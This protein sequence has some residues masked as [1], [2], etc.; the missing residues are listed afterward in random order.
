[1]TE[2]PATTISAYLETDYCV[3]AKQPFILR[4]EV[5]S[6]PLAK[7]YRLHKVDCAVFVTACNPLSQVIA[8]DENAARQTKLADE[9]KQRGLVYFGGTGKH[10]SGGWPEEP[11]YLALGLSLEAAKA[12]GQKY[13]QNA[14]LW[15][16]ADAIPKL[17]LLR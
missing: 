13:G 4:A 10:P 5:F 8:G 1:M 11:S 6:E 17:V 7:L 14:V 15:C 3:S 12:L 2:I 9:L 16:G